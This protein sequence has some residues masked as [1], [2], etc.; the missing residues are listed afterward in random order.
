M[1]NRLPK[2]Y[3]MA[4][5]EEQMDIDIAINDIKEMRQGFLSYVHDESRAEEDDIDDIDQILD[6][7]KFL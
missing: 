6:P 3:F 7:S 5:A 1:F 2:N 4:D